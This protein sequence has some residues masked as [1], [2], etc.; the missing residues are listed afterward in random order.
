LTCNI[1]FREDYTG[2]ILTEAILR[3]A[4][5]NVRVR[6]LLDDTDVSGRARQI[7]TLGGHPR[8]EIRVFNPFAYRG[9]FELIRAVEFTLNASRLDSPNAQ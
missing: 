9:S 1:S 2:K 4:D 8:I 5:R 7:A 3:A 6:V